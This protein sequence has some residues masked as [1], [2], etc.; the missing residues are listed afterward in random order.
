MFDIMKKIFAFMI[1]LA[2][3]LSPLSTYAATAPEVGCEAAIA[4]DLDSG[5]VLFEKDADKKI[6]PASTTKILTA[7]I[8][9]ENRG[10]SEN[11]TVKIG[12]AHV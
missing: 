7:I 5:A 11:V 10:L 1:M 9:I 6:F 8:I 12:R 4:I 3:L 2:V